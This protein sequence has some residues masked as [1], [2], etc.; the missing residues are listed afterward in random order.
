MEII[1]YSL[2]TIKVLE[3]PKNYAQIHRSFVTKKTSFKEVADNISNGHS[4]SCGSFDGPRKTKNFKQAQLVALDFDDNE[5]W[6]EIQ[7]KLKQYNLS[8]N[9]YYRTFSWKPDFHKFRLILLLEKNIND[10]TAYKDICKALVTL[11]ACDRTCSDAAKMYLP[12]SHVEIINEEP[13]LLIDLTLLVEQLNIS[14]KSNRAQASTRKRLKG[15]N[16]PNQTTE[17]LIIQRY[18][19]FLLFLKHFQKEKYI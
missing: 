4:F 2:S 10:L 17:I 6:L 19:K 15:V 5:D 7:K 14:T 18:A 13:N 16:H 9:L 11:T 8:V 12:G 3:K 1:E